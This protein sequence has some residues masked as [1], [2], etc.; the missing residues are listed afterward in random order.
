M[1]IGVPSLRN[2][3]FVSRFK[4][5]SWL[6]FSLTS[7]PI[8]LL[9]NSAVFETDY[10]GS[11]FEMAMVSESFVSKDQA[12]SHP[13]ASFW[14]S[15]VMP[16]GWGKDVNMSDYKNS[17]FW[18]VKNVSMLY[19]RPGTW[20]TLD[21]KTC[22]EQY[23]AC[24]G[25]REYQS[26][27]VVLNSASDDDDKENGWIP[28]Q[29]YNMSAPVQWL[30]ESREYTTDVRGA[31]TNSTTYSDYWKP[32]VSL[33]ET[34]SLWFASSCHVEATRG[35]ENPPACSHSCA[36]AFG[37]PYYSIDALDTKVGA[38][39]TNWTFPFAYGKY[40]YYEGYFMSTHRPPYIN[41][42]SDI[43]DV[44]YCLAETVVPQC[45]VGLSNILLLIITLC[46]IL[47]TIQCI[48][49]IRKLPDN[50]PLVTPG[51]AVVSF[52]V[53]PDPTTVN[54]CTMSVQDL[55][56]TRKNQAERAARNPGIT[57]APGP[58]QWRKRWK[59]L[60]SS[61]PITAWVRTSDSFGHAATNGL[62]SPEWFPSGQMIPSVLLANCPQLILSFS[63][64]AYNAFF[65]RLLVEKEWNSFSLDYRPLRVTAPEGEQ[66]S[67]YRLQL[68]YRYSLPLLSIS[69]LLH[70]LVSNTF[71]VYVIEGGYYTGEYDYATNTA[72]TGEIMQKLGLASDTFVGIG[73]ST[74]AILTTFMISLVLIMIP[75]ALS[76]KRY[77]GS[78]VVAGANSM[79]IS[80]ACHCSP[81]NDTPPSTGFRDDSSIELQNLISPVRPRLQ[82]EYS[83]FNFDADTDRTSLMRLARSKVRWGV[84]K[85]P[86]VFYAQFVDIKEC[87]GHLTFG[88]AEHHV[89]PPEEG[90]WYA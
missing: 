54:K 34:N 48:I 70:W 26:V 69:V 87:V 17:D 62:F 71:Y 60:A 29:I 82:T 18:L 38:E 10:Q 20:T 27:V 78:M 31:F 12:Y 46:V 1:E 41:N 86:A 11:D 53:Y 66:W 39:D 30:N 9:F 77:Q 28:N 8:H 37:L 83:G 40:V 52:L 15:G 23:R 61:I 67:T 44:S 64:F 14:P 43:Q 88:A 16:S 75:I 42:A 81:I 76:F 84:V 58:R 47:K 49:V 5:L 21:A 59:F 25:R 24:I 35:S 2:V 19:D 50:H 7:I 51:D 57:F 36:G 74:T 85:M 55:S 90:E 68:P 6:V 4:S 56:V 89:E 45:K 33:D 73:F 63:Y 80:A 32:Y 65:T 79:V 13:G 22:K 3:F 72:N